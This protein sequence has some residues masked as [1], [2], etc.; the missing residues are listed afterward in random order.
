MEET[1]IQSEIAINQS[2]EKIYRW[3]YANEEL[4][5][6]FISKTKNAIMPKGSVLLSRIECV[7]TENNL[8]VAD[9][10][11]N[12]GDVISDVNGN[13]IEVLNVNWGAF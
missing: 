8:A 2:I 9:A 5:T 1:M 13:H 11:P 4:K 7:Y 6:W 12:I 3:C 10:F